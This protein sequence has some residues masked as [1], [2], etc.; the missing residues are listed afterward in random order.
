VYSRSGRRFTN[1]SIWGLLTLKRNAN[2]CA[3]DWSRSLG[4]RR[5]SVASSLGGVFR[6]V[7]NGV[8]ELADHVQADTEV[9]GLSVIPAPIWHYR[10]QNIP[11]GHFSHNYFTSEGTTLAYVLGASSSSGNRSC[12]AAASTGQVRSTPSPTAHPFLSNRC[13]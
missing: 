12:D 9:S 2:V 3:V 6:E 8:A 1:I 13:E 5:S 10:R 11:A 4:S 7:G